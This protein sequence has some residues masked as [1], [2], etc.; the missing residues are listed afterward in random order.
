MRDT[1]GNEKHF[2]NLCRDSESIWSF[3]VSYLNWGGKSALMFCPS[4]TY[5]KGEGE[6]M[7]LFDRK[8]FHVELHL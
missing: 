7:E 5:E 1:S 4:V 3:M 2:S 8:A 6:E